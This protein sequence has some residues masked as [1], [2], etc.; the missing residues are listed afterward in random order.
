MFMF[1]LARTVLLNTVQYD[2]VYAPNRDLPALKV[3]VA[4]IAIVSTVVYRYTLAAARL[5]V[6][7]MFVPE[8]F[9]DKPH[10]PDAAI[11][12]ILIY[13][14]ICSGAGFRGLCIS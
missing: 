7:E 2:R 11:R 12:T 10:E 1:A 8:Y 4:V 9:L 5:S 3:T 6:G 14:Q 13:D